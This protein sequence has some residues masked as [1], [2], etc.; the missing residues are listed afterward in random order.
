VDL[1][2]S[3]LST[4]ENP[5][6]SRFRWFALGPSPRGSEGAK[7]LSGVSGDKGTNLGV[8]HPADPEPSLQSNLEVNNEDG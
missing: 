6:S 4:G 7:Q 3:E 5:R 8:L 2:L 1:A